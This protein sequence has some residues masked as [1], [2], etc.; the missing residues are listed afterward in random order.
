MKGGPYQFDQELVYPGPRSTEG[1]MEVV[2]AMPR[3]Q[4][5]PLWVQVEGGK[6]CGK[7]E[8]QVSQS[9]PCQRFGG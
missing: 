9:R 1:P 3:P 2:P 4:M 7:V 8:G 5:W 6:G